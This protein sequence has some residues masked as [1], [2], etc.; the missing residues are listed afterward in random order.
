MAGVTPGKGGQ[1]VES[2]PVFNT[3]EQAVQE[4]N[5]NTSIIF[6]PA[7][8]AADAIMEAAAA[9]I[10]LVVC[11]HRRHS[12]PGYGAR[13]PLPEGLPTHA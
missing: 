5:A 7:P 9:G 10:K 3:V 1:T 11:H 2:V 8:G 4:T 12:D 13:G 6:V